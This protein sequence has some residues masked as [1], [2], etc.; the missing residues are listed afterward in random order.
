MR[1]NIV[2]YIFFIFIVILLIFAIYKVNSGNSNDKGNSSGSNNGQEHE[3]IKEIKLAIAELDTLNPI[4]SKNK[5]VQ[6]VDKLIYEP[7]VNLTQ[8]YKAEPC[9]ATEWAKS[10]ENS[11]IIKLRENVEWSNGDKFNGEDVRFTIDR[12]KEIASI[13]SYNVQNITRVDVVDNY[14][15]KITLDKDVP[16]FEYNLTFPIMSKA[17]Y[18]GE[19]FSQT[20]K[21]NK[22]IGTGIFKLSEIGDSNFVLVKND[23]WWNYNKNSVLE[24]VTV[25]INSSMAEVYNA[26][27]MGNV[28][29][30]NTSNLN[31]KDYI[32]T[33]G[34]S[35]KEYTAREHGFLAINTQ[36]ELLSN[37][38]VRQ[39]I[40][41]GIDKNN[42]VAAA[43]G[44]K[45]YA[46]DFPLAYGN[47][48]NDLE[49]PGNSYDPD[50]A[51]KVLEDNG[52]TLRRGNWQKNIN[53][54]TQKLNFNL[55]VKA[56]DQNRVAVANVLSAQLA[57]IGIIINVREV[58]DSVYNSILETKDY[59]ILLG[60]SEVSASPDLTTYFGSNNL[61]NYENGEVSEILR[62]VSN[63]R[64]ENVIKEK[65][66]RL[67]EIYKTDV[68][69]VSLYFS[70]NVSIYNTNLA[71]EVTPN[72][73]NPFYNIENWYK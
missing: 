25:N 10:D 40:L 14:T 32:G 72:W 35:T 50:Y 45:W 60:A 71:G 18:N 48:L 58:N 12:L 23:K 70:K 41:T 4:L 17:Y 56:S 46:T 67:K 20:S 52:W 2:K 19:D 44:G 28:D 33:L 26:F 24:K 43:F 54:R 64:D 6:E 31:Y 73:F 61:A 11:Y 42:V 63:T 27:K 38:E 49:S 66:K 65:Y 57:N 16:F 51:Y 7:L 39:A 1:G 13:Y 21:N 37:V 53:Y 36:N 22:P 62:E 8:D 55:I 68:P 29:F 59:D 47:W 69:Y 3:M 30:V 15:V 5:N 9:L 34:Y